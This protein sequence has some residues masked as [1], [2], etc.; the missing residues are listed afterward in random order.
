MGYP[1]LKPWRSDQRRQTAFS[2]QAAKTHDSIAQLKD[3]PFLFLTNPPGRRIVLSAFSWRV[4]LGK[5]VGNSKRYGVLGKLEIK[6]RGLL[7]ALDASPLAK[8]VGGLAAQHI[9]RRVGVAK[10]GAGTALGVVGGAVFLGRLINPLDNFTSPPG[11]SAAA[12][13]GSAGNALFQQT[14]HAVRHPGQTARTLRRKA[15]E[16]HIAL[17]PGATPVAPTFAQ[18]FERNLEIG[19]NQGELAFNG[20]S[21]AFGG[22]AVKGL[23]GAAA[24][25][26]APAITK[27][28]RQGY[29]PDAAKYLAQP[30]VGMGS[31]YYPRTLPAKVGNVTVPS[32]LRQYHLPKSVSDSA[33]NVLKPKDIN[34]GDMYELHF[35]VDDRFGGTRLPAR[36]GNERWSG[37]KSGIKRHTLPGRLWHG[38]PPPLKASVSGVELLGAGYGHWEDEE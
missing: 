3:V 13:L 29:S 8:A 28:I 1:A 9:G 6:R 22:A 5:S 4:V 7:T 37:K 23:K 14:K 10:A 34:R 16:A 19:K 24:V 32:W 38:A 2:H 17:N 20:G 26:E 18:E 31:H 30:Y 35:Q 11:Q 15:H 25:S 36:F 33:F 27:F 21:L 12:Q